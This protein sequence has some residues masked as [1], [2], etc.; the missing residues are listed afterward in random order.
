MT[1]SATAPLQLESSLL[2][3][4]GETSSDR[5]AANMSVNSRFYLVLPLVQHEFGLCP[6]G[7]KVLRELQ[8]A[9]TCT[10]NVSAPPP[11][12]A[13]LIPFYV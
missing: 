6:T 13:A 8:L 9:L 1:F 11:A 3:S 2:H 10:E 5:P 4:P 7:N 12:L